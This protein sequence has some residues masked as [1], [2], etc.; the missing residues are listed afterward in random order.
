VFDFTDGWDGKHPMD[1]HV[2]V[3]SHS[4]P[5]GWEREGEWFTFVSSGIEEAVERAKAIAGE[6]VVGVNGGTIA[7]QCLEARL[8]DEVWVDLVPVLL[9]AGTPFFSGLSAA[10]YELEGPLSIVDGKDVTHLRYRVR[11]PES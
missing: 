2:V 3:L 10:P 8:L 7:S 4:V 5:D 9:G 6:K 11:Y 1:T